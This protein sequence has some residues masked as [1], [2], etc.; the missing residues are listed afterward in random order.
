VDINEAICLYRNEFA[1][2]SVSTV[3][4]DSQEVAV[5]L[6]PSGLFRGYIDVP[7]CTDKYTV[8]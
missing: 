5:Y 3:I 6:L 4:G 7:E 1:K 8:E 2:I